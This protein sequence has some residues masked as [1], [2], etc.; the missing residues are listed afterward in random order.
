[1]ALLHLL[2]GFL[3]KRSHAQTPR[4]RPST[5]LRLEHLEDRLTPSTVSTYTNATVQITPNMAN[6]TATETITANVTPFP[7]YNPSTGQTTPVPSGAGTPVGAVQFNLNNQLKTATLNANGQASATFT[8]PL[9]SILTGQA[10]Q[11]AYTGGASGSN[12][13]ILSV[14]DGP[15]YLNANNLI[16]PSTLTFGQLTPQQ[17]YISVSTS[18]FHL[19]SFSTAQGETEDF[20]L[21][22]YNYVDPGVIISMKAFGQTLPGYFALALDA[23]SGIGVFNLASSFSSSTSST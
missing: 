1:M 12:T 20:G 19:P 14:F 8:M 7:T 17:S 16:L 6:L 5:R 21:F 13:Y 22:S 3:R 4:P 23:Y 9:L 15:L 2:T 18:T 10:V 11:A